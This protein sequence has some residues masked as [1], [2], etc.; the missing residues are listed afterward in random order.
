MEFAILGLCYGCCTM[1]PK[2]VKLRNMRE[3]YIHVVKDDNH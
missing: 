2:W 1:K 3:M